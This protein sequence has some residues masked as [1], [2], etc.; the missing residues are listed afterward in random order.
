L[1]ED[2]V[3]EW[4]KISWTSSIEKIEMEERLQKEADALNVVLIYSEG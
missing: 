2:F 4:I 3:K 1:K